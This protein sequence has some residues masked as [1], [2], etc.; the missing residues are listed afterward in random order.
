MPTAVLKTPETLRTA[1]S[2]ELLRGANAI[3]KSNRPGSELDCDFTGS[4]ETYNASFLN[5]S[6]GH[7]NVVVK[8]EARAVKE[9]NGKFGMRKF[10]TGKVNHLTSTDKQR[11]AWVTLCELP[12]GLTDKQYKDLVGVAAAYVA[13]QPTLKNHS[14]QRGSFATYLTEF[15]KF[16]SDVE[17]FLTQIDAAKLSSA[18]TTH[19]TILEEVFGAKSNTSLTQRILDLK[20]SSTVVSKENTAMPTPDTSAKSWLI[21]TGK[22]GL[23][24]GAIGATNRKAVE[25]LLTA[26]GPDAPEWL[27]SPVAHKVIE[28][29]IPMVILLMAELDTNNRIP[30]GVKDKVTPVAKAAWEDFTRDSGAKLTEELFKIL[31]PLVMEYMNHAEAL[32][33]LGMDSELETAEVVTTKQREHAMAEKIL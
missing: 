16:Q 23:L 7:Y 13:A 18:R 28:G 19:A 25:Q 3:L 10:L 4:V 2:S 32:A 12:D 27:R 22:K 11:S 30:K 6:T 15:D 33:A 21:E 8:V 5:P 29:L 31:G 1:Q 17:E 26:M 14:A 9:K 20:S 24:T